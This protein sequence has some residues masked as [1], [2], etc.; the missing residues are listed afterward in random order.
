MHHQYDLEKELRIKKETENIEDKIAK[1]KAEI[2][3]ENKDK[4]NYKMAVRDKK[5]FDYEN[6]GKIEKGGPA[7]NK[8][9]FFS[10][11]KERYSFNLQNSYVSHEYSYTRTFKKYSKKYSSGILDSIVKLIDEW[12]IYYLEESKKV[13][14]DFFGNIINALKNLNLILDQNAFSQLKILGEIMQLVHVI[15]AFKL[16]HKLVDEGFEGCDKLNEDKEQERILRKALEEISD[17]ETSGEVITIEEEESGIKTEKQYLKVYQKNNKNSHLT[18]LEECSDAKEQ[19]HYKN[20]KNQGL[21]RPSLDQV[22]S[23]M[24]ESMN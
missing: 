15:R 13:I 20:R 8:E 11:L 4:L 12:I 14:N 2:H 23:S 16:I 7:R 19:L 9:D 18:P 17:G 5:L 6:M 10:W 1:K 3:R 21:R 22:Y 24:E